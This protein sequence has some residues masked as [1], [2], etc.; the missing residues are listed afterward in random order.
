MTFSS[1]KVCVTTLS[2]VFLASLMGH[3]SVAVAQ[4]RRNQF[5]AFLLGFLAGSL[6]T[7]IANGQRNRNRNRNR[8]RGS[9]GRG[10]G[11]GRGWVKIEFSAPRL[12]RQ[13]RDGR[14]KREVPFHSWSISE[15]LLNHFCLKPHLSDHGQVEWKNL[16]LKNLNTFVI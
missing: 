2:L 3:N 7:G 10:R 6:T 12:I 4:T 11:R 13:T 15:S 8:D 5:G 1:R 16:P 9:R 14:I